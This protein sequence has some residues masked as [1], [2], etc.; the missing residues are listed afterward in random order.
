VIG[1]KKNLYEGRIEKGTMQ[2]RAL[3]GLVQQRFNPCL[4][5]IFA[6]PMRVKEGGLVAGREHIVRS[7]RDRGL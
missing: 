4:F 5:E 1:L 7:K 6:G 2:K 3:K